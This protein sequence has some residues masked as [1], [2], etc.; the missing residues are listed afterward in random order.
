MVIDEAAFASSTML[1]LQLESTSGLVSIP[2]T[3]SPPA[4]A[5][6][7]GISSSDSPTLVVEP[8]PMITSPASLVASI[9]IFMKT[10]PQL[11]LVSP[12]LLTAVPVTPST[13]V[14]TK[15]METSPSRLTRL[16]GVIKVEKEL[17]AEMINTFYKSLK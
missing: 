13:I 2:A 4:D 16:P 7:V 3:L 17:V 11:L 6:L 9:L 10:P 8:N 5:G 1:T 15:I 14:A 12:V